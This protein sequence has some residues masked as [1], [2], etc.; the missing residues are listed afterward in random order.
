MAA[1]S[2]STNPS[3]SRSNGRLAR[4]GASLRVESAVSRLK[5]V[6]PKGWIMLCVPPE[7][8][9]SASPRRTISAAS[10]MAW[11]DAAHAVRQLRLGPCASN[12]AA[13]WPAG[14][15][16]SCSTSERG[17]SVSSPS[18]VNFATSRVSPSIAAIIMRVKASKSC[19]PSPLPR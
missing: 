6:T 18:L 3:R 1:P 11:L 14:M 5:P 10:P 16:G 7:S 17:W 2:P 9:T 12:I 4:V 19:C 13:R 15:F 8:I